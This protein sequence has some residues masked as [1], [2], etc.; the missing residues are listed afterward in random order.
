VSTHW[1]ER[2]S[3]YQDG[4]LSAADLRACEAH[5]AECPTC[6]DVLSELRLVTASARADG[7]REP[8][9]DLWPG[10]LRRITDPAEG[11][12]AAEA[13]G[14]GSAKA[15]QLGSAKAEQPGSAKAEPYY[16]PPRLWG[17]AS[18]RPPGRQVTFSLPQLALAASLLIAVSAGLSY[19][20]GL[21]AVPTTA[22]ARP[23]PQEVPI[24]AM[25]EDPAIGPSAQVTRAN[26][27]DE[28]FDRAIAD[29]E[30]ILAAQRDELDPRTVVVIERNLAVI[31]E[32]IRQARTALDAD[33]A[34]T[35]LNSHLAD[36]RRRKLDLLRRATSL[37][38]TS[39][40]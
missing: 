21:R 36:A 40:G 17:R 13:E 38:S 35:F 32:A 20:A 16:R 4:E 31:D 33:P 1:T 30:Q 7:N 34:N 8:A 28:Q 24:Q 25:S 19:M 10:I 39:G 26:F 6:R 12:G 14:L 27:A 11:N 2:L 37:A 23:G 15:E 3:D 5:L 22:G 9:V 18:A 29:L